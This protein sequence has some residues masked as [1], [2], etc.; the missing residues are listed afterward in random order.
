M[1]SLESACSFAKSTPMPFDQF[2][3]D[4]EPLFGREGRV[5]AVVCAV[6]VFERLKQLNVTAHA[7]TLARASNL[8]PCQIRCW[9]C[10]V[11]LVRNTATDSPCW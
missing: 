9:C 1:N 8:P 10:S 6:G 2:E 5:E 4:V 11:A 7:A 3:K